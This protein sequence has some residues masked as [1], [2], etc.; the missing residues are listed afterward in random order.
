[1]GCSVPTIR[2]VDHHWGPV[3]FNLINC[4]GNSSNK[5]YKWRGSLLKSY[6][7]VRLPKEYTWYVPANGL[8]QSLTTSARHLQSGNKFLCGDWKIKR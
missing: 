2:T 4:R 8:I 7:S 6:Q 3:I 1:L 5:L